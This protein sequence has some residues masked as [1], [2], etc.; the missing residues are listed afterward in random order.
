VAQE[1]EAK[2]QIATPEAY[3]QRLVERG[4]RRIGR[5]LEINRVFD[6]PGRRLLGAECGL[7]VRQCQPVDREA[8]GEPPFAS[9]TYKGPR[10]AAPLKSREELETPV[11]DPTA[12]VAILERLGFQAVIVYEKRREAW[13]LGLCEITLDELPRLGWWIE[14][15]G[16]DIVAIETARMQLGLADAAPVRETYV[17]MAAARGELDTQGRRRLLF[18]AAQS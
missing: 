2:F 13:Q 15:E 17:E 11:A 7:R 6:T 5:V 1:I 18:V 12:L 8:T 16:P 9:L 10:S 14:I 3:R 4:A